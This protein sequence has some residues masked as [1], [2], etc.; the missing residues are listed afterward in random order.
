MWSNILS[1]S[2]VL[3]A[4]GVPGMMVK[5]PK[6]HSAKFSFSRSF[7][8]YL[9]C[10]SYFVIGTFHKLIFV[11]LHTSHLSHYMHFLLPFLSLSVSF[12]ITLCGLSFTPF[13]SN[14]D[15][16]RASSALTVPSSATGLSGSVEPLDMSVQGHTLEALKGYYCFFCFLSL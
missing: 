13:T 7:S 10:F 9:L 11:S 16:S 1:M 5:L 2:L 8:L 14:S 4:P 6:A 15:E 3:V 12:S